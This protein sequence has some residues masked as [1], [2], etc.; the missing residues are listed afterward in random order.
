MRS[1]ATNGGQNL[2][3]GV[4]WFLFTKFEVDGGGMEVDSDAETLSRS[5]RQDLPDGLGYDVS[6]A[7][8]YGF[9]TVVVVV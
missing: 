1:E 8:G 9:D 6:T 2:S 5:S 7:V 3:T 4:A